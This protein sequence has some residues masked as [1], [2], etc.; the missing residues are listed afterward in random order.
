M[1]LATPLLICS[2]LTSACEGMPSMQPLKVLYFDGRRAHPREAWL[3]VQGQGRD[4]QGVLTDTQG[5]TL[6]RF[7]IRKA[8]WPERTRHGARLVELPDDDQGHLMGQIQAPDAAAYD[9]WAAACL[10]H[11]ESLVVRAQQSW[12]GVMAALVL[13]VVGITGF[14]LYGLPIAA[15]GITALVPHTVDESLGRGALAQ[16]DGDMMEPSKLAPEVQQRL[17]EKFDAAVK[18]AYPQQTPIH[19]LEFRK[20]KV[21]PNAFALP[22]GTM[23]MTDELVNLVKDDEVVLG[24]MGHELGHVTHR[25]GMRQL[26]QLTVIQAV[27]SVAFGDYGSLLTAAPLILGG[28]A[29][30]RAH[31]READEASIH[32]MQANGI[33][34]LV[35]VKFFEAVRA[36][37]KAKTKKTPLGIAIISTHPSDDERIERFR[38]AAGVTAAPASTR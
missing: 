23:V 9:A 28:A 37:Q 4:A 15:R 5:S 20:S 1:P 12:R 10:P 8:N 31:E 6:H 32:F 2:T 30:S 21:G 25:H 11:S 14:Y 29:Y 26:V 3:Q 16:V 27:L 13:L 35:M 22:G 38:R 33:S 7:A 34:P 18:K 19:R 36:E 24:V 17:R